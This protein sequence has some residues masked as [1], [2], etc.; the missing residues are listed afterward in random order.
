VDLG[1]HALVVQRSVDVLGH[2]VPPSLP[3]QV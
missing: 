3:A 2:V 1:A